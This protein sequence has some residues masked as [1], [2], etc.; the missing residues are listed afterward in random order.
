[1]ILGSWWKLAKVL[2]I[3]DDVGIHRLI[4]AEL[5]FEGYE[6]KNI[7]HA[8]GGME[9]VE[10]FVLYKPKFVLLDMIM[11]DMDGFETYTLIKDHDCNANVMLMTGYAADVGTHAAISMGINGY[12]SKNN[13]GYIKLVVNLIIAMLKIEE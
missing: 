3:D 7:I 4:D 12:I 8:Y 11:P 9:G 13:T 1:M 2:I 6:T 10:K 5:I